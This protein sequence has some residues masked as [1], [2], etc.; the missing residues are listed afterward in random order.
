MDD[1]DWAATGLGGEPAFSLSGA[2]AAVT[3]TLADVAA[4]GSEEERAALAASQPLSVQV[5]A[6][7]KRFA[8][9][10]APDGD[11]APVLSHRDV[12]VAFTHART[13]VAGDEDDTDD[14]E[15]RTALEHE[16]RGAYEERGEPLADAGRRTVLR[17][18]NG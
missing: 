17:M 8:H 13:S 5:R 14:A 16:L 6:F 10:T 4:S 9:A 11:A 18:L 3:N 15:W 7:A 12:V 1:L 2:H